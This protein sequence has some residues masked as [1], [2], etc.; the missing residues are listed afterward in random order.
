MTSDIEQGKKIEGQIADLV[1][2]RNELIGNQ[3]KSGKN[4][5]PRTY[6]YGSFCRNFYNTNKILFSIQGRL[7]SH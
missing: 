3:E 1:H 4:M 6:P 7:S 5:K 2:S